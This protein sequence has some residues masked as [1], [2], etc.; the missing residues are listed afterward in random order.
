MCK[1]ALLNG[2]MSWEQSW[3]IS[4]LSTIIYEDKVPKHQ[5]TDVWVCVEWVWAVTIAGMV[6]DFPSFLS[7]KQWG[8]GT[9]F[10]SSMMV[11]GMRK[12]PTNFFGV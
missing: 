9:G 7:P 11:L 5:I 6:L 10:P 8:N 4:D 3:A 12:S 2:T 1:L